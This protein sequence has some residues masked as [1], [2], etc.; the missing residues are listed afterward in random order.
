MKKVSVF[1]LISL[2]L[3]AFGVFGEDQAPPQLLLPK[4]VEAR[5]EGPGLPFKFS[6]APGRLSQA[7]TG[8]IFTT[9]YHAP[10]FTLP[11]LKENPMP[12]QYPRWAVREGWEGT[13]MI[14][15]E[16][17]PT[18]VTGLWKVMQ[19]TGYALLDEAATRAIQKWRFHP[20][21]EKGKAIRSCIQIPVHFQLQDHDQI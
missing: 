4:P 6:L 3:P 17:L 21:Q 12:I 11:S 16:I 8:K 13:F 19:S 18:G 14:A 7:E 5:F 2:L 1:L 20:A 10:D 15:I 9:G